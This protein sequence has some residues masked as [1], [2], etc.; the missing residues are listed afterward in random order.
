MKY[1]PAIAALLLCAYLGLHNGYLALFETGT[2]MPVQVF[3]YRAALYP[4]IDQAALEE[5]IPICS[6][7]QL[8]ARLE[9]FLS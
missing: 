6:P 8:K 2:D 5:G 9:D 1:S 4:K 7:A 3:P